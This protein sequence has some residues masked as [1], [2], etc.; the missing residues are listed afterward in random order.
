M[1]RFSQ[2]VGSP[3]LASCLAVVVFVGFLLLGMQGSVG[4]PMM[5]CETTL[6]TN[7]PQSANCYGP[8]DCLTSDYK[9]IT[10]ASFPTCISNPF[11]TCTKHATG[12]QW[13]KYPS[14]NRTC[15]GM[16][17]TVT[18]VCLGECAP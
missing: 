9:C 8:D 2:L 11:L 14:V 13:D 4:Q 5:K 6:I 15:T 18:E 12:C 1:S 16:P 10:N 3:L 17:T 7:C